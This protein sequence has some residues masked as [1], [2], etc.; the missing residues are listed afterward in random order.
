VVATGGLA[1]L[2]ARHADVIET[3]DAL[4]TLRGIEMILRRQDTQRA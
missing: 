1:E 4:L 3:V 2:I